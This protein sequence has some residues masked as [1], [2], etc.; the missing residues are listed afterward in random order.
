M[1][2]IFF[3]DPKYMPHLRSVLTDVT[4]SLLVRCLHSRLP[5]FDAIYTFEKVL[6]DRGVA[7][8]GVMDDHSSFVPIK[9][10]QRDILEVSLSLLSNGS[11]LI[12]SPASKC[13]PWELST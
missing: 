2:Q 12:F 9:L 5:L 13:S 11:M 7:F 1:G 10:L 3:S 8:K 4:N 6:E